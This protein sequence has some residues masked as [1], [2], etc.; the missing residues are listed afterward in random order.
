MVTDGKTDVRCPECGRFLAQAIDFVR[1]VCGPCGC[2]V[3]Y[4][5]RRGRRLVPIPGEVALEVK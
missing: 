1:V 5:S 4:T 2:E 3:I